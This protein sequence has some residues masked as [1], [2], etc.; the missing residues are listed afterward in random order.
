MLP[1][2]SR[3]SMSV[4]QQQ[5]QSVNESK[6]ALKVIEQALHY[7]GREAKD[8]ILQYVQQ[9]YGMDFQLVGEYRTEF[10][11]Y[12]RET[13]Q[14][15]AE[16]IITKINSIMENSK[17]MVERSS[18]ASVDSTPSSCYNAYFLFCDQCFWSA[19]LLRPTFEQK[20]MVC[21]DQLKCAIPICQNEGFRYEIN[22]KR[23]VT[24]SFS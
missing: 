10:E 8:L 21:G 23:G 2:R 6:V 12:L 13:F 5:R 22:A 24:L 16:I 9:K 15:S 18:S 19:S 14:E 11:N 20:C 1:L 3:F 7:I 17:S 4:E